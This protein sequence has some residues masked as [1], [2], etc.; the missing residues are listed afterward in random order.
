MAKYIDQSAAIARLTH[1][2]VTK[3][4]V[5]MTDAKRALADMFPAD[6]APVV[7]GRWIEHE[8]YTFGTMYDCS[9]CS[10]RIL[11]SG[12]SWNYCPNC[13]AKMDGAE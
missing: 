12:H 3:P 2:E 8:K 7:Y 6:V 9:I 4:T 10:T 11:D 13:G 5:T 1:L